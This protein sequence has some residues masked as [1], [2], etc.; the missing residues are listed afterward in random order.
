MRPYLALLGARARLML[1]YRAAAWAG[2]GTQLFW[3]WIRV[4]VFEALYRSTNEPQPLSLAQTISYVWLGQALLVL[5]MYGVESETRDAIRS[6]NVAYELC[7]PVDLYSVWF[8]RSLAWRA[9][10]A[11]LRAAPQL[12]LALAFL[13]LQHP[14][15]LGAGAAWLVATLASALLAAAYG[16]LLT[17]TMLWTIAG[18]GIAR[19]GSIL[20]MFLSGLLVPLPLLPDWAST[21]AAWLPFRGLADLPFRLWMGH[22]PPSAL[23]WALGH[24]LAWT[25][26]LVAL[27]RWLVR[28]GVRRLVVQG[29]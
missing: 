22:L 26:V 8:V 25:L 9:V 6:G 23:W 14:P 28:R 10:A 15:S 17:T 21:I 3:G 27:G 12:V 19:L 13:G 29:G 18:D 7:R 16:T 11:F 20:P 4:M 2:V 1:Q 5:S 24:Q